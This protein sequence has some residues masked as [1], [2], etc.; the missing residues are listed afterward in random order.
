MA[1]TDKAT[2]KD[3]SKKPAT[4]PVTATKAPVVPATPAKPT[5]P[6]TKAK[7][8]PS[9][10]AINT[11][12]KRTTEQFDKLLDS[13]RELMEANKALIGSQRRR[14]EA[15]REASSLN[16]QPVQQQAQEKVNPEDFVEVDPV[17]GDKFINEVKLK[18]KISNLN[19]QATNAQKAVQDYIKTS[20]AREIDRQNR[21]TF[22]KFPE[23]NPRGE[24]F[25]KEFSRQVRAVLLDS[26]MSPNDYSGRALDFKEAASYVKTQSSNVNTDMTEPTKGQA[27]PVE[28]VADKQPEP[29]DAAQDIK[30]QAAAD[31]AGQQPAARPQSVPTEDREMLVRKTREGNLEAI[32]RR[33]ANTDHVGEPTKTTS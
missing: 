17:T 22:A 6:A 3:A 26:M 7:T 20:E 16:Q 27:T 4:N 18:A 29:V 28:P 21:E 9:K 33:L 5:V 12:N 24:G 13:N 32:A 31:T 8:E 19:K 1:N 23:L 14:E 11:E 10:P 2:V 25:D 30:E 15:N